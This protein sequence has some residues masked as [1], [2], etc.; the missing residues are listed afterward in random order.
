MQILRTAA[1]SPEPGAPDLLVLPTGCGAQHSSSLSPA[2]LEQRWTHTA[3]CGELA[4]HPLTHPG[5]SLGVTFLLQTEGAWFCISAAA[6]SPPSW[7]SFQP[8]LD[9]EEEAESS[10][11]SPLR[12]P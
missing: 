1:A 11:F 12:C 8:M 5:L 10:S 4:P 6:T 9:S 2:G 7:G 3:S